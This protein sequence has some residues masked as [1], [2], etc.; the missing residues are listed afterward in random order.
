MHLYFRKISNRGMADE[1]SIKID[2]DSLEITLLPPSSTTSSTTTSTS[3]S[4]ESSSIHNM[5]AS[6]KSTGASSVVSDDQPKYLAKAVT[7]NYEMRPSLVRQ[8]GSKHCESSDT[9]P[10]SADLSLDQSCSSLVKPQPVSPSSSSSS[11]R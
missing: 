4:L 9:S 1:E 5:Q 7:L 11:S 10:P 8:G 2:T 3:T 6:I